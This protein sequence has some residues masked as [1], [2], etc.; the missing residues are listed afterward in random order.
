GARRYQ[1]NAEVGIGRIAPLLVSVKNG[2]ITIPLLVSACLLRIHL[3]ESSHSIMMP[4][5]FLSCVSENSMRYLLTALMSLLLAA[6]SGQEQ[7]PVAPE[8][9]STP[10][11]VSSPVPAIKLPDNSEFN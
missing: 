8:A 2:G 1:A 5:V 3:T 7:A 6:C 10:E 9:A 4:A 11:T